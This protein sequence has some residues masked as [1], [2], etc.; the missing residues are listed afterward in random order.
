MGLDMFCFYTNE[1][2]QTDVDFEILES[3]EKKLW[4]WR[5]H[6]NLHGWMNDLYIKKN[7]NDIE[8]NDK[9]LL[10]NEKDIKQ[11]IKD[12]IDKNLPFTQGFFFGESE[13]NEEERLNDFKFCIK[14]LK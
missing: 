2:P 9:N 4:Y 13:N 12:I 5:K 14:A 1:K 10:L 7:G 8:F 6:P 11:L 3:D